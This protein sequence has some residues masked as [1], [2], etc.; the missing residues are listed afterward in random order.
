MERLS[1]VERLLLSQ[2]AYEKGIGD[3]ETITSVLVHHPLSS[4]KAGLTMDLCSTAY[5]E[6]ME[7]M[8]LT[9]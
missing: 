4:G 8:G 7:E 5:M 3:W 6:L 2:I 9:R 1:D